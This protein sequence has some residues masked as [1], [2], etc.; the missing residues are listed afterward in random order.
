MV[1][2]GL[3]IARAQREEHGW[4]LRFGWKLHHDIRKQKPSTRYNKQRDHARN[5]PDTTVHHH[6]PRPPHILTQTIRKSRHTIGRTI[7]GIVEEFLLMM[8]SL[9]L[10]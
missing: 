8:V 6:D 4:T 3:P 2:V 5:Q 1:T 10:D 9:W 7:E